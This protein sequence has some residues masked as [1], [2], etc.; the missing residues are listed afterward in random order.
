MRIGALA[1]LH[2]WL[3]QETLDL[4]P[5]GNCA[6][7]SLLPSAFKPLR[8]SQENEN[9]GPEK[10]IDLHPSRAASAMAQNDNDEEIPWDRL[11]SHR[12]FLIENRAF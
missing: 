10:E 12:C 9:S 11:A 4:F 6:R 8:Q 1:V 3:K 2:G 7:T 5:P